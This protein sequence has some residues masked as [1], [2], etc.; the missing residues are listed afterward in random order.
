MSTT[1]ELHGARTGNCLRAAI[2]LEECGLAYSVYRVDLRSGEQ[3]RPAHL[4]LNRAGKVPT[5]IDRSGAQPVIVSQSNAIIFH[6]S[7]RAPGKLLPESGPARSLT[8]E[9][10]FFF[11][12]DVVVPSFDGF[13][14]RS[15]GAVDG[16]RLLET[17]V[18]EGLAWADRYVADAPFMA[19]DRFSMA[20]IAAWTITASVVD[21]L[22]WPNLPHLRR[23]YDEVAKRPGIDRGMHAFDAHR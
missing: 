13:Y 7:D 3:Y 5:L 21:G 19:G 6:A 20:D 16:S 22:D 18:I 11:V 12:T 1:M 14:L 4:A 15:R 2:A 8:L 17:R 9:R 10:F 23:W